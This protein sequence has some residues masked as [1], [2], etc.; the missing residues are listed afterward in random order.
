MSRLHPINTSQGYELPGVFLPSCYNGT[1]AG[2]CN[3]KETSMTHIALDSQDDA[4]KRFFLSLPAD[5]QGTILEIDGR[6]FRVQALSNGNEAPADDWTEDKNHRRCLL[7]DKEVD[8]LISDE[9]AIELEELQ[10]QLRRYRRQVA[11]LPLAE[12]RRLLEELERKAS[13]ANS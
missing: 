2:C 13:Q 4:V 8:G 7:I 12:T 5:P 11:P 10:A 6:T 9:E 1:A 3:G